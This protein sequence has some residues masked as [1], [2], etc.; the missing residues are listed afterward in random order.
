MDA[1]RKVLA[2]LGILHYKN[3]VL[4]QISDGGAQERNTDAANPVRM[5]VNNLQ[6]ATLFEEGMRAIDL[7]LAFLEDN[8]G[9]YPDWA[10]GDSFTQYKEFL[11]QT[12]D[13]FQEEVNI[14]YSRRFFRAMR[15]NIKFVETQIIKKVI[16]PDFYNRLVQC[17]IDDSYT[18]DE[19]NALAAIYPV[20]A[21]FAIANSSIGI[22]LGS[23]GGYMVSSQS[24]NSGFKV[25]KKPIDLPQLE[26]LKK[27]HRERGQTYLDDLI[28]FLN[29]KASST[30][31]PLYFNSSYYTNPAGQEP[32]D[33]NK[34]LRHTYAF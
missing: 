20:V 19:L 12:T 1:V 27:N 18:Q 4:T 11:L 26:M 3:S 28:A 15:S 13:Q 9:D 17:Q 24:Q 33:I 2:P 31:Y 7:L 22:E 8:K 30:V 16:G 5:W 6:S 23:D 25:D 34:D 14:G 21:N 29:S 32:V 10:N